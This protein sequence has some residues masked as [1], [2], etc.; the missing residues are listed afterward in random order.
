MPSTLRPYV[1]PQ[2]LLIGR[3]TYPNDAREYVCP[4]GGNRQE[5]KRKERKLTFVSIKVL[6]S[7][8]ASSLTQNR[9]P[10]TTAM[11]PLLLP[12]VV[13]L[14]NSRRLSS[15]ASMLKTA[16]FTLGART[17]WQSYAGVSPLMVHSLAP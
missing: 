13:L 10:S 14:S 7:L 11:V 3:R 9:V 6:S 4:R 5:A 12:G 15:F 2:I 1:I 8:I 16:S 17:V